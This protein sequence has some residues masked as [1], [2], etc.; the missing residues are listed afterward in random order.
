MSII[1]SSS[2]CALH[3]T[4][5]CLFLT[6]THPDSPCHGVINLHLL[7]SVSFFFLTSP[8]ALR[9][10]VTPPWLQPRPRS[11]CLLCFY[12]PSP[13]SICVEAWVSARLQPEG[14]EQ[15]EPSRAGRSQSRRRSETGTGCI[16][17]TRSAAQ[18]HNNSAFTA[19]L[20]HKPSCIIQKLLPGSQS[21][22]QVDRVF[23]M[24]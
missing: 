3:H 9:L 11:S 19:A 10:S 6:P 15:T 2:L 4:F 17:A 14:T 13:F 12:P 23:A 18:R 21:G 24:F 7:C 22:N 5:S 8:L 1:T 20:I 16:L